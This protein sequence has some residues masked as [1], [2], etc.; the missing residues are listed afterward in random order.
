MWAVKWVLAVVVILLVLGFALQNTQESVT[1]VFLSD[2]WQYQNVQLWIVIYMSFALG[3]VFWL[4]VSIFQV[5]QLK[6]EIRKLH[7]SNG[8]M[9]LELDSLR[10]LSIGDDDTG[11]D[12]KEET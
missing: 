3:V 5:M 12:L 6:G 10:N 4:A 7:K 11:F 9:Q 2:A 1:V 8:E